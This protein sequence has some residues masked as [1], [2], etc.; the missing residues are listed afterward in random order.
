MALLFIDLD[1][2]KDIN[3]SIGHSAGDTLLKIVSERL[4]EIVKVSDTISRQ[5]G[6]EFLITLSDVNDRN[7]IIAI[8]D[9]LLRELEQSFYINEHVLSASASIGI[10]V[11]PENGDTFEALL[12]NADVAMYT[13]KESG[14]NTY[15]FYTQQMNHNRIGLFKMQNDLK[16]AL[17]NNENKLI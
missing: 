7:D 14:K 10:A 1:G 15:C 8:A 4:R 17:K 11:Y 13:A 12:K 6:D 3:D 2:F 5:G 9:R 16:S